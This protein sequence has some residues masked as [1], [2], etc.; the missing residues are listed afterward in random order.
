M[1]N[2]CDCIIP[3]HNEEKRIISVL[4]CISKI[5]IIKK[6]ICVDDGST[7][8]SS[9]LVKRYFPEYT[10]VR[11]EKNKGKTDTIKHGLNSSGSEFVLLLDADISGLKSGE[12]ENAVKISF[13]IQCIHWWF[14]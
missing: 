2:T 5:K 9:K 11:S 7:D 12:L 10:L 6:V 1:V 13:S 8:G 4:K 3:F 14:T